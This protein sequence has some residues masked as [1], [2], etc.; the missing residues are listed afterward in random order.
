MATIILS[1]TIVAACALNTLPSRTSDPSRNELAAGGPNPLDVLGEAGRKMA[2]TIENNESL[3][4]WRSATREELRQQD[5]SLAG[6]DI[7]LVELDDDVALLMWAGSA[8]DRSGTLRATPAEIVVEPGPRPGCDAIANPRGVV[9]S[10][11]PGIDPATLRLSLT[12]DALI[13][14]AS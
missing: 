4:D 9:L 10:F 11:V 3:S 14:A 12:P 2:V 7:V 13:P 5:A 1:A 6:R 8:C